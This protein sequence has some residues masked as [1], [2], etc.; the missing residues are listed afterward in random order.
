MM[1]T[2]SVFVLGRNLSKLLRNLP[3]EVTRNGEP[4][5]QLVPISGESIT[6]AMER[7]MKAAE[8]AVV[9]R[10]NVRLVYKL[11]SSGELKAKRIGRDWRVTKAAVDAYLAGE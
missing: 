3:V 6:P 1:K 5:A 4:I 9:L 10:I 2:V 7:P 11:I 8:V